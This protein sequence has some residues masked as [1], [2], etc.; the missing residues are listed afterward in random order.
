MNKLF[1]II[2]HNSSTVFETAYNKS[3]LLR[4]CLK[5]AFLIETIGSKNVPVIIEITEPVTNE[6][7]KPAKPSSIYDIQY[8]F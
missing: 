3:N 6:T 8:R 5:L 1:Q 4:N 2:P 7:R